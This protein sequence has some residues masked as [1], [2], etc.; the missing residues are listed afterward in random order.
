M[1]ATID[2]GGVPE[3][4]EADGMCMLYVVMQDAVGSVT[5]VDVKV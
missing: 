3:H 1:V 5:A 2:P 4:G